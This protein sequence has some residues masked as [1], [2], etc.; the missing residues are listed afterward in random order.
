MLGIPLSPLPS[1]T[2]S[3]MLNGQQ[4]QINVY[5]KSTGLYFDLSIVNLPIVTGML[6]RDRVSLIRHEYLGFIGVI[7]F[8]DLQ[9]TNDPEYSGLGSRYVL[10]YE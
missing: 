3:V 1:Q 7:F 5:Q 6:C 9:G 2:L 10:V 4:C 8:C